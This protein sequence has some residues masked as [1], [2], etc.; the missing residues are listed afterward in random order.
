MIFWDFWSALVTWCL[1]S[2]AKVPH[3]NIDPLN[4]DHDGI[5]IHTVVFINAVFTD[6]MIYYNMTN[7]NYMIYE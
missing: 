3:V 1:V 7:V 5:E 6:S 4:Q 2:G